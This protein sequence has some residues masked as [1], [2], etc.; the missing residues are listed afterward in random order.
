M[1]TTIKKHFLE[2]KF[3]FRKLIFIN[4]SLS[5]CLSTLAQDSIYFRAN[6][7]KDQLDAYYREDSKKFPEK[8][9]ILFVGSS[10]IKMWKNLP[11]YFPTHKVLPRGFGGSRMSD[12]LFHIQ[13]LVIDY[14]PSQIVLYC[15]ENDISN[16]VSPQDMVDDIKAFVRII[17]LQ[18]PGIPVLILSIKPSPLLF[19]LIKK[20]QEAN[21]LI[22]EFSLRKPFVKFLDITGLMTDFKGIPKD[23]LYLEDRLHIRE[24]AYLLWAKAIEPHLK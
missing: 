13:R 24:K 5:I 18:L 14:R 4:L 17:E 7:N 23:S 2:Q 11:S 15:G 8:G 6:E 22:Y 16:G 20:Q 19:K 9:Q 1:F 21:K 3:F 10:S 12:V